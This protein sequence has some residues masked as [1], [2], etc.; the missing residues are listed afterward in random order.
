MILS[1]GANRVR[2]KEREC[3]CDRV[4]ERERGAG[5]ALSPQSSADTAGSRATSAT[6]KKSTNTSRI[7]GVYVEEVVSLP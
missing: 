6:I 2:E 3:V 7:E 5:Q 1:G 4:S